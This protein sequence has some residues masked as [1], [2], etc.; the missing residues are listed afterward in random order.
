MIG[1]TN[2]YSKSSPMK[3]LTACC[4]FIIGLTYSCTA[5]FY[6]SLL[7]NDAFADSLAIIVQDFNS[8]FTNIEGKLFETTNDMDVYRSKT[9][10][11]GALHCSIYRSH[12]KEDLSA[13]WHAIMYEGENYDRALKMYKQIVREVKKSNISK[14]TEEQVFFIGEMENPKPSVRF[15]VTT[16][17]LKINEEIFQNFYA[18]IEL[19]GSFDGWMVQLNLHNKKQVT[20]E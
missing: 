14:T 7:P 2:I 16:L 3:K 17:K 20:A 18:E 13:S 11:P 15:T 9:V 10:L 4:L 5:Q 8:N 19:V 12:S 1:V 6:K